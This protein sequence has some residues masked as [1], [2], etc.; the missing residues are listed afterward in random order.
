MTSIVLLEESPDWMMFA[1][2][3]PGLQREVEIRVNDQETPTKASLAGGLMKK[4]NLKPGD[5]LSLR[6]TGLDGSWGPWFHF[7]H[8]GTSG[9]PPPNVRIE[10]DGEDPSSGFAMVEFAPIPGCSKYEVAMYPLDGV[11]NEWVKISD[12]ITSTVVRK[13][14]LR[15]QVPYSFKVRG[16]ARDAQWG[17]WSAASLPQVAR[18]GNPLL[19]KSLAPKLVRTDGTVVD[20]STLAGK[21]VLVY[22]SAHWCPPCRNYTPQLVQ[23]Y[24]SMKVQGK[25]IEV[26]F[27]SAD[28]DA[29]SFKKYFDEMGWLAIPYDDPRREEIQAEHAV[30]GIPSLKVVSWRTGKIVEADA[31]RFPLTPATFDAWQ[32]R[33]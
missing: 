1:W 2:S 19:T 32:S 31:I 30:R 23:F 25:S 16:W 18:E 17:P 33:M 8:P 13:K 6:V 11:A 5:K 15:S 14:N 26:V 20:A 9:A 7:E 12:S 27:V 4:K 10:L 28:H 29:G 21:V 24:Q 3:M 22:H